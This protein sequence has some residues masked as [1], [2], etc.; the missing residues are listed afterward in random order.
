MPT[1][2]FKTIRRIG[3]GKVEFVALSEAQRG[4]MDSYQEALERAAS[5][6][7]ANPP[8]SNY[9]VKESI[10]V[11]DSPWPFMKAGNIEYGWCQAIHGE[12]SAVAAFRTIYGRPRTPHKGLVLGIIAG[13]PEHIANPCGNCRDIM[14]EDL[15][16]D[17]EIVTGSAEGGLA[18]VV[19]M[20]N[21]LFDPPIARD[22]DYGDLRSEFD[23]K[24]RRVVNHAHRLE[25]DAYAPGTVHPERRYFAMIDTIGGVFYGAHDVMCEYHPIYAL[26]DAVRQAR[27]DRSAR[28]KEVVIA[29][30]SAG[31]GIPPHVMYKDRQ[32]LMELNL[33]GELMAGKEHD[34][35]VHLLT[36]DEK[37]FQPH[38]ALFGG[39]LLAAWTTS[40][41]E[42]LPF[43]FSPRNFGDEFI[44]HLTGYYKKKDRE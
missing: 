38:N 7:V 30:P 43:P 44:K 32:H 12:E 2:E 22:L 26:R 36:Y 1:W 37:Q 10:G 24:L 19:K 18:V 25:N 29:G 33:Q 42:W 3:N 16:E 28:I 13:N 31:D 20:S 41:K 39:A 14:L 5:S 40:V 23:H 4:R 11:Q 35:P 34:P 15:G 6:N 27:R 17:F 21:Y 8:F 9:F